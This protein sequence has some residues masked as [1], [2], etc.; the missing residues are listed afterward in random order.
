MHDIIQ[1][2]GPSKKHHYAK[3][4]IIYGFL[5]K[6]IIIGKCCLHVCNNYKNMKYVF[7]SHKISFSLVVTPLG[8][9]HEYGMWKEVNVTTIETGVGGGGFGK[10]E[11]RRKL[12]N[13]NVLVAQSTSMIK[14]R[15]L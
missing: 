14:K 4:V 1:I 13:S 5:C 9:Q 10:G 8:G 15:T 12:G 6:E 7:H 2:G 3:F 11:T